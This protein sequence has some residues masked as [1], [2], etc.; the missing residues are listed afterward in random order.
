M[1]ELSAVD[2]ELL[3]ALAQYRLLTVPQAFTLGIANVTHLRERFAWLRTASLIVT[4]ERGKLSG[5]HVHYLSVKGAKEVEARSEGAISTRGLKEAYY[6]TEP[7]KQRVCIV[8]VQIALRAWADQAGVSVDW[9]VS[10]FDPNPGS[11]ERATALFHK[12]SRYIADALFSLTTSDGIAWLFALEAETGGKASRL[13]NFHKHLGSRLAA[14]EQNLVEEALAWPRDNR[15]KMARMLYVFKD[16]AMFEAAKSAVGG[17]SENAWR[18]VFFSSL[19][20]DA[21]SFD[22]TW[23]KV[24]GSRGGILRT[25]SS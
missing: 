3:K 23:W 12:G 10:D 20:L 5:P 1:I 9:F 24:D 8:D 16:P 7:L 22:A 17:R 14:L 4:T 13:G 15:H 19:P 21:S 18:R 6:D 2:W 25:T 11:Y